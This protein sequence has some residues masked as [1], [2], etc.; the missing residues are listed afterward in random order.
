MQ[1]KIFKDNSYDKV[2]DN[3]NEFLNN[4]DIEVSFV[5]HQVI[6]DA[7]GNPFFSVS[8]CFDEVKKTPATITNKG[9]A[10]SKSSVKKGIIKNDE[11]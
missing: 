10:S 4:K 8:L 9:M 7:N 3:V 5:N 1:F 2:E 11:G 6:Q